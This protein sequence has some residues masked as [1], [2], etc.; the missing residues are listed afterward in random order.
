MAGIKFRFPNSASQVFA[1]RAAALDQVVKLTAEKTGKDIQQAG[2]A[3][4]AASGLRSPK[5]RNS[6][7]VNVISGDDSSRI[8]VTQSMWQWVFFEKG[9]T[10]RGKPLWLPITGT[11]TQGLTAGRYAEQVGRLFRVKRKGKSDLLLSYETKQPLYHA[12]EQVQLAKRLSIRDTIRSKA[13]EIPET[14]RQLIRFV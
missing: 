13:E 11:P 3:N 1:S 4:I 12:V 10:I 9:A 5:W 8:R 6:L 14:F 7:K 2:N